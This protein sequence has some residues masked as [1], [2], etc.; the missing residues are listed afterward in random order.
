[1]LDV[2]IPAP[3]EVGKSIRKI[4]QVLGNDIFSFIVNSCYM[5]CD[6]RC[7]R[8]HQQNDYCDF[9]TYNTPGL[10]CSRNDEISYDE[11][12]TSEEDMIH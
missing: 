2:M 3:V 7:I 6:N 8:N 4:Y 9:C 1:M 11:I 5:G 10:P 12:K